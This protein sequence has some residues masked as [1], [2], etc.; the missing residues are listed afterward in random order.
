MLDRSRILVGAMMLALAACGD[1]DGGEGD[2]LFTGLSGV[3][4][5]ALVIWFLM[6]SRR[7]R[8]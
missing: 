7:N 6:R 5:V 2:T 1:D 3:I 4:I 8:T